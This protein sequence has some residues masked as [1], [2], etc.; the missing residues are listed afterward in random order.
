MTYDDFIKEWESDSMSVR[1]HT[2]GS[3]GAP[4]YINISKRHMLESAMRTI[5]YFELTETSHLH[6]CISPD[7]IGGKMVYVRSKA[8]NCTFSWETPSNKPLYNYSGPAIDIVSI[9]PSQMQFILEN[10]DRMP[11][12]NNFLIGG[13]AI[14]DSLRK[15]I[16]LARLNAYE[17]YGM[18]ETSSHVAIRKI[19]VV[20]TPF[21]TLPGISVKDHDG[22]LEIN[23]E[24]WKSFETND[25]AT[26][27]SDH[28][29]LINGRKDNIIVSGGI[30]ICPEVL[31]CKLSSKIKCPF[32][33][34]SLHDDKWGE[35]LVLVLESDSIDIPDIKRMVESELTG[36]EKPK[37]IF[38]L[39]NF[40][41]TENGKIKRNKIQELLNK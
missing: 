6:S 35:K 21:V 32:I 19:S 24:G 37:D 30:K 27:F 7:F 9:V 13:S 11:I 28:E 15:R 31:E 3:T 12:I 8:C 2:S 14:P 17:S 22:T 36:F 38:V 4:A 40:P 16:V 20:P 39:N 18:T 41:R 25:C 10:I 1:C 23:I 26:V 34:S 33:L 29:F 5:S